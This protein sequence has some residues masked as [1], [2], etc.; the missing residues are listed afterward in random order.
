MAQVSARDDRDRFVGRRLEYLL[1]FWRTFREFTA[2]WPDWD[3]YSQQDFVIEWPL[4]REAYNFIERT[5]QKGGCLR[6]RQRSGRR[7]GR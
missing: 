2:E 5:A 7:C 1:D 3:E 4:M 6:T